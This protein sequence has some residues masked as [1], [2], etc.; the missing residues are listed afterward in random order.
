MRVGPQAVVGGWRTPLQAV[1]VFAGAYVNWS[2]RTVSAQLRALAEVSVGQARSA[3]ELAAGEAARDYELQR[4]GIAN[5]GVVEAVAPLRGSPGHYAIVTLERTTAA[6]SAAYRGLRPAW[7]VTLAAVTR[8][9][10]GLWV[11]S[12]W[13]PES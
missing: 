10:G 3:M 4:A 2:A 1:E 13:Q 9:A 11:L 8:V 6:D 12:S 7:H 5:S